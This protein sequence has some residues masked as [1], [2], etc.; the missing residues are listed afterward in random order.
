ML[1]YILALPGS[2]VVRLF[3]AEWE[4]AF[5]Q[6]ELNTSLWTEYA[7]E[8]GFAGGSHTAPDAKKSDLVT[9]VSTLSIEPRVE[10][11]Y[12]IL[13][14]I[15]ERVLGSL[16]DCENEV[17][18]FRELTLDDIEAELRAPGRKHIRVR[19]DACGIGPF[20]PLAGGYVRPLSGKVAVRHRA[21]RQSAGGT[22]QSLS[23]S[24]RR[25]ATS[26]RN[27][28]A[29]EPLQRSHAPTG[30]LKNTPFSLAPDSCQPL[31][32]ATLQAD[33]AGVAD[34]RRRRVK[35]FPSLLQWPMALYAVHD[36]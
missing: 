28:C 2:E 27:F 8:E 30:L 4:A 3:R 12:W 24:P 1:T 22:A 25:R 18:S 23:F 32:A 6:P 31:A 20:R 34:R 35:Y 7:I 14:V 33:T 15:I 36:N 17:V 10:Q 13:Q 9:A 21:L 19:L 29:S 5:G 11:D 16:A 26:G